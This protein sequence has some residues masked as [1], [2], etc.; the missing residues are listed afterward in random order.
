MSLE[1]QS[2]LVENH[3][4][5]GYSFGTA[6]DVEHCH[7]HRLCNSRIIPGRVW[8]WTFSR[9]NLLSFRARTVIVQFKALGNWDIHRFFFSGDLISEA[10]KCPCGV[11]DFM[12][13]RGHM[14]DF[15]SDLLPSRRVL[16]LSDGKEKED[17]PFMGKGE[18][19]EKW[20]MSS[21]ETLR[22][23]N[24]WL[25][26]WVTSSVACGFLESPASRL[27]LEGVLGPSAGP[28]LALREAQS[29]WVF[30]FHE[31]REMQIVLS[32]WKTAVL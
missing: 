4:P 8:L 1:G 5:S 23:A 10:C 28:T 19:P 29:Y 26:P 6:A 30:W 9:L 16:G 27:G 22:E 2:P 31:C 11:L 12:Q 7:H 32:P 20:K 18:C 13:P 17:F 24:F 21:P 25:K 3:C 14:Y 15:H